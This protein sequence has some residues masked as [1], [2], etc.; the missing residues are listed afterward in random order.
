MSAR[1]PEKD[2]P[3]TREE[4]G[5]EPLPKDGIERPAERAGSTESAQS[6]GSEGSMNPVGSSPAADAFTLDEEVEELR[7]ELEELNGK[8]LRALADLDNYRKRVERDRRRWAETAREEVILDVLEVVDNFERALAC[9]E[10]EDG[11]SFREGV[12]L[13]LRQ[14]TDVLKKHGVTPI[15]ACDCEFDPTVHEAVGSVD[16]PGHEANQI[17][18][19][20]QR[21]YRLGD[22]LLRCSKV[23]VSK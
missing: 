22:R 2:E 12:E 5:N 10:L 4:G 15:V 3:V 14:L 9:D 13:I 18:E 17:V 7:G 20:T 1:K 6:V 21:G 8:W 23:I 19:E 16:S 11:G